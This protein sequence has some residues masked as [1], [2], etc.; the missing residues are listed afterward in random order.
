MMA[1]LLFMLSLCVL[2][3]FYGIF[4]IQFRIFPYQILQNAKVALA[5]WGEELWPEPMY[6][7]VD[8]NGAAAPKVVQNSQGQSDGDYILMNGVPYALQ[9][10]CPTYGCM[11]WIMDRSGQIH[12]TWEI[13]FASLWADTPHLGIKDH[14]R[15]A[16]AGFHLTDEGDLLVSFQS[17]LLFPYGIGMAKFDK[18]GKVIWK[19]A[20]YSHHKFSVAPDGL[21][22]TPANKLFDNPVPLGHT[23]L[24]LEC[25]E[26]KLYSDVI[27]VLNPNGETIE[28]ID[29]LDLLVRQDFVGLL[30]RR[31]AG[32]HASQQHLR[33]CDPIHLNYVEYV[34]QGMAARSGL[35]TGDLLVSSRHLN[36]IAAIDGRTKTLKW[37][38]AGRTVAQHSPRVMPDGSIF[39]FDNQGGRRES[40]GSRIVRLRYGHSDI[41]EIYPG[42]DAPEGTDF[43]T[44]QQGYIEPHPDGRRL[45]VSLS[46]QGRVIELDLPSRRTVWELHNTHDPGPHAAEL[47]ASEGELLRF[48]TGGA[49]YVGRPSF[50]NN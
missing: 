5:A 20:N 4:T 22:Y 11:A 8:E 24:S 30:D 17:D 15:I 13:N 38:V 21:I 19:R 35:N 9:S 7:F 40:G 2:M 29:L 10:E 50:L 36:M 39:A 49:Y 41:E 32:I 26:G 16:P 37:V 48:P 31:R 42:P 12:H 23:R 25:N 34:T 45:L 14:G 33:A 3:F 43:W 44:E 6:E 28:E 46:E 47:G 1:K 18:D 27:L